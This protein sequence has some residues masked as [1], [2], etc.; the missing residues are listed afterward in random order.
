MSETN[1]IIEKLQKD[2]KLEYGSI[3]SQDEIYELFGINMPEIGTK[4]EFQEPI[5]QELSVV[6]LIKKRLVET[7]RHIKK[8]GD[9]YR[10]ILPNENIKQAELIRESM[11]RKQKYMATLLKNTPKEVVQISISQGINFDDFISRNEKHL[12]LIA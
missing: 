12:D 4:Q 1:L 10:I 9:C 6:G 11:R 7:G 8:E 5:L 2:G 3:I